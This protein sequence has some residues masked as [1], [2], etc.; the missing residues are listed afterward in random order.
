MYER[1]VSVLSERL[2]TRLMDP[3]FKDLSET[4]ILYH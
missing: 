2:Q 4:H 1:I 3:E